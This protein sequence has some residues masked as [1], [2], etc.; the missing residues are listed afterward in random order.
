MMMYDDVC[1][2]M[3]YVDDVCICLYMYV[4]VCMM[5]SIYIYIYKDTGQRRGRAKI[6]P[7]LNIFDHFRD[8]TEC[9]TY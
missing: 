9:R 3:M 7:D 4:Y 8:A 2:L 5:M 1:M 6:G